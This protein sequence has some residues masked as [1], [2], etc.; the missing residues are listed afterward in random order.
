[1][2]VGHAKSAIIGDTLC[3]LYE[4]FGFDVTREYYIND[5]GNQINKL[6]SSLWIRYQQSWLTNFL[7]YNSGGV[8]LNDKYVRATSIGISIKPP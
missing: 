2:H 5:A 7:L 6:L 3:N 8:Q 4:K 1:M